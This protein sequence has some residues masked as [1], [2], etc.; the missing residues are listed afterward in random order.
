MAAGAITHISDTALMVAACRAM[1]TARPDG[2][3]RDPFAARLAGERG[4][5]IGDALPRIEVMCFGIGV[6]TRF[7]DDLILGCLGTEDVRTVV[8]IGCGLDTRPWRLDLPQGIRWIEVDFPDMLD[9]KRALMAPETPRC[10]LE[11]LSTDLNLASDR[12]RLFAALHSQ[13]ALI[14]TEG[15]LAYLPSATIEAM[16]DAAGDTGVPRW[17]ALDLTTPAFAGAVGMQ[18]YR[19]IE[20][21]RADTHLDGPQI[22]AV[23]ERAGWTHAAGRQYT[24]DVLPFGAA[25]VADSRERRRKL[26]LPDPGD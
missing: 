26:G 23:L 10:T 4:K 6:R 20:A 7:F 19:D 8:S 12:Q 21:M 9:Y 11:E 3:L 25:R 22:Q 1:E 14:I 2:F 13:P 15:L 17:W 24:K 18:V 5:A 16:A